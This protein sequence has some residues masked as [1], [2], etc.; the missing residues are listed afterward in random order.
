ML[1]GPHRREV[2]A[3]GERMGRLGG[4][5]ADVGGQLGERSDA[6]EVAALLKVCGEDSLRDLL[7]APVRLGEVQQ[8]VGT[9]GIDMAE[10]LFP[11]RSGKRGGQPHEVGRT[12]P[13]VLITTTITIMVLA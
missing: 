11:H 13:R 4:I 6:R 12:P 7:L 9:S 5:E 3:G 10:A 1:I 8:L 2:F